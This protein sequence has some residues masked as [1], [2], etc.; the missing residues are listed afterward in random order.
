MGLWKAHGKDHLRE[1]AAALQELSYLPLLSNS[2][3]SSWYIYS[4]LI[5]CSYALK[6]KT[7]KQKTYRISS[8]CLTQQIKIPRLHGHLGLLFPFVLCLEKVFL[9]Q[10]KMLN[11]VQSRRSNPV[12]P[13]D[14]DS[15]L[16]L[17]TQL[18]TLVPSMLNISIIEMN[19]IKS[20]PSSSF[21]EEWR[22]KGPLYHTVS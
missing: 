6:S 8:S 2:D 10:I 12:L 17:F 16:H 18:K 22:G 19:K 7:N 4:D 1:H 9:Q 3:S 20:S 11:Q 5:L 21:T 14:R 15:N 13:T